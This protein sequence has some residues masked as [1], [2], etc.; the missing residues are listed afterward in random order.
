M[1]I[2]ND[3]NSSTD[4]VADAFMDDRD[5]M[6]GYEDLGGPLSFDDEFKDTGGQTGSNA[7]NDAFTQQNN[8]IPPEYANDPDLW[9]AIQASLKVRFM[10]EHVFICWRSPTKNKRQP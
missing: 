7:L 6:D 10:S 9:Y 2:G 5:N 4:A 3:K 8:Q 1:I